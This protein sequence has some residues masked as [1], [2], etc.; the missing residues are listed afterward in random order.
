M[1]F[2]EVYY[3]QAFQ[4]TIPKDHD[5]TEAYNIYADNYTLY[6][7]IDGTEYSCEDY[8][9]CEL[10]SGSDDINYVD[11]TG[12]TIV[13]KPKWASKVSVKQLCC[14][15]FKKDDKRCHV[16]GTEQ[17]KESGKWFCWRHFVDA[18]EFTMHENV[19]MDINSA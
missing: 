3:R 19:E 8:N 1:S 18:V 12:E 5:W 13:F 6:Y 7:T 9:E 14:G 17:H 16:R 2:V 10:Q 15:H 4:Y 11:E